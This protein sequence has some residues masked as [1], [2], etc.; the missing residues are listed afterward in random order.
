[1]L[2]AQVP[3]ITMSGR[4]HASNVGVSL[5]IAIGGCDALIAR[6]EQDYTDKAV[7]LAGDLG[8]Y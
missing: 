8:R 4:N 1:M 7:A 2:D 5:L 3:V 6:S